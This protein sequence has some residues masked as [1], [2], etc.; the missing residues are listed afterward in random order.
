MSKLINTIIEYVNLNGIETVSF[1]IFDT[2]IFRNV[3]CPSDIFEICHR[4]FSKNNHLPFNASEFSRIRSEAEKKARLNDRSSEIFLDDIYRFTPFSDSV[5]KELYRIELDVE[6]ENGFILKSM[7]TL[8]QMLIS[9]GIS[10]ILISDMYLS[11]Q[12]IIDCFFYD[13]T[14]IKNLPI[15][16]SC[17]YK[18]NKRDGGMYTRLAEE[19]KIIMSKWLHVGDNYHSDFLVPKKLGIHAKH[20]HTLLDTNKIVDLEKNTFSFPLTAHSARFIASVHSSNS[21][22]S[23]ACELGSF[24]WGP[25]LMSFADWVIEKTIKL[26]ASYILCVMREA[27]VF[28]PLIE[29]RI[30]QRNISSIKVKKLYASRKSTF[31]PSIDLDNNMWFEDLIHTILGVRGYTV[32]DFYSDFNLK[33]DS[34]LEHFDSCLVRVVDGMYHEGE[35]LLKSIISLAR[36]NIENVKNNILQQKNS[37][38]DYYQINIGIPYASCTVVDLGGG[39]TIQHQIQCALNDKCASNLLFYSSERIYR[40]VDTTLYSSFINSVENSKRLSQSLSRS[41]ECIEPLLIGDSGT[42]LKYKDDINVSPILGSN[43]SINS[44]IFE[45]FMLGVIAYFKKH[46]ELGFSSISTNE[47]LPILYRYISIPTRLEAELFTLFHHEDNFGAS[48]TYP[49]ISNEQCELVLDEGLD[50]F[51]QQ[52][53]KTPKYKVGKIHWPQGIFALLS[54]QF[55][56]ERLGLVSGESDNGVLNLLERVLD[57]KWTRFSVYGAG[58]FFEKLLPYLQE[59]NLKIDYLIDRKADISGR[60]NV[61]GFDVVSLENAL[62]GGANKILI[63]SFAF[64]NEIA[65]NIYEQSIKHSTQDID[66]L[67]L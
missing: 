29:L 10:V 62:A 49:V 5:S 15:Y 60:Y 14:V 57:K 59:N 38:K 30:Q 61:A 6:K 11:K 17:D 43:L 19:N 55:L 20:A 25:I 54:E 52:F 66:V 41:P 46:V 27:V 33:S 12:Q 4:L 3:S 58:L 56:V 16:V 31:W 18:L 40:Y 34:I 9:K 37:F 65:K 45:E 48:K 1:D 42:T 21:S 53:I 32:K 2:I 13:S 26:N 22:H 44:G 24:V 23:V 63:S 36:A 50:D 7:E 35:N 47:I 28:A 64:K 8:I 39:G 67:S 51:Y